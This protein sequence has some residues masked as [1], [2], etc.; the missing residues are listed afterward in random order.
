MTATAY[1]LAW[2]AGWPRTKRPQ[3]SR[4]KVTTADAAREL[5]WEIQRMGGRYAVISTNVP[6]SRTGLLYAHEKP[7]GG[8]LT[9]GVAV[10][11][12]RD[13]KQMVFACDRWDRVRGNIQAIRKSI[14]AM[15]GIERWGASD[16][17]ERAFSAFEALPAPKSC[18]ETLGIPPRSTKDQIEAAYRGKARA[19]HPD[20]GGST[21]AM[22]ALNAARDA[23]LKEME[24]TD[25]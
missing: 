10:Y 18:W 17:M 25:G 4:F 5:V 15:R 14:E 11:F 19:A 12:E 3:P 23:A 16:M 8:D 22:A 20:T 9:A 2:P 21:A 13:G 1:P 6:I 24:K 7:S